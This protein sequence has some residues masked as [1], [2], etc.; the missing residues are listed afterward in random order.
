M[1]K[2]CLLF[3]LVSLFAAPIAKAQTCTPDINNT[4]FLSPDTLQDFAP[5]FSGVPYVQVL[6]VRVPTDTTIYIFPVT[7]DS[8]RLDNILNMPPNFTYSCNS[9]SCVIYGGTRGCI[10]ITGTA[11]IA[12]TG[13]W[14]LTMDVFMTGHST[15]LGDSTMFFALK[16]YSIVVIDSAYMGVDPV[17]GQY[18]FNVMQNKP[19]PVTTA[20]EIGV[21]S[22]GHEKITFELYDILG[23]RVA[24]R[25]FISGKGYNPIAFT[26]GNLSSGIY[27]YKVSNGSKAVVRRMMIAGK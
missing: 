21:L 9:D 13:V 6:Q 11:D 5:A 20:T 25:E 7:V 17:E 14:D 23:A 27:L 3:A 19:N 18:G 10:Q 1:K 15:I 26:P 16:G 4:T 2:I 22:K 24:S 12:D 8:I